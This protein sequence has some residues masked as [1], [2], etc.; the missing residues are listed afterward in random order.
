MN[1]NLNIEKKKLKFRS[2][3]IEDID[4]NININKAYQNENIN[5][6]KPYN[7]NNFIN[8]KSH[9]LTNIKIPIDNNYKS[10]I[11]NYKEEMLK[12][13][14]LRNN[15][16]N[17]IINEFSVILGEEK[18]K[19]NV[20]NGKNLIKNKLEECNKSLEN[21]RTIINVNQF[22]PSYYIANHEIVDGKNKI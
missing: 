19:K 4:V 2:K 5:Y 7:K 17:Q 14:I 11:K 13:S 20:Q 1:D 9:E 3:K 6:I 8:N 22:Y 16:N 12:Y 15:Q 10:K 21:K 18:D